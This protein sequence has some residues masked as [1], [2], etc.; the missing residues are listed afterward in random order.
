MPQANITMKKAKGRVYTPPNIVKNILDMVGYVGNRIPCKHIIDNSCGDGA[1]LKEIVRRYCTIALENFKN[2]ETIANE[3]AEYIH[4]IEIDQNAVNLCIKNLDIIVREYGIPPVRWDIRCCST[5]TVDFY[6]NTMDYVVGNPPYVRVHN[7]GNSFNSVKNFSFA[8]CGMTDLF[9]VFYEIGLRMLKRDGIL[10]YI[11]PSSFFNSVAGKRMRE[12]FIN[13]NLLSKIVDF[14]HIQ[15]F[16]TVTTYTT[17]C[18]LSKAQH[19]KSLDYY[20]YDEQQTKP[21]FVCNL[22]YSEIY[23]AGS[24][25]FAEKA[26]LYT[27]KNILENPRKSK[28]LVKNGFATLNDGVFANNFNFKSRYIIPVIKASRGQSG[29]I[30][31]PYTQSGK[32]IDLQTLSQDVELYS[33]LLQNKNKLQKRS[34]EAN[35]NDDW[36]AYGRSQAIH[37]TFKD[38]IAIN[39]LLRNADDLKIIDAPAGVGVYS[40]LYII[41]SKADL[42][43]AISA[44]KDTNFIAYVEALGKYKSGGYYTFSSKDVKAYLDYKLNVREGY[45]HYDE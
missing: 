10:G 31:F 3:L 41:G 20:V 11:S 45:L 12:T 18:I 21:H 28:L 2:T 33:Y 6:D 1:F 4:G 13:E 19:D 22:L 44:L 9:I 16:N 29:S 26:K 14:K 35:H 36:Y 32:L 15:V 25:Y 34:L 39:T 42:S 37:D 38:K 40:G 8:E 30:I 27:L 5:L 7:L 23:I 17:I 24:F 43:N